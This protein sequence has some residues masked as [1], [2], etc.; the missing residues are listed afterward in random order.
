MLVPTCL[1]VLDLSCEAPFSQVQSAKKQCNPLFVKKKNCYILQLG[2]GITVKSSPAIILLF[3][4]EVIRKFKL[5][6]A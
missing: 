5:C 2:D 4:K 6:W 1:V 3:F